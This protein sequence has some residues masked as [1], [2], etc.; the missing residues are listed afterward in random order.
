M[1]PRRLDQAHRVLDRHQAGHVR[2]GDP[3]PEALL[4]SDDE[5]EQGQGVDREVVAETRGER[6]LVGRHLE[7]LG[8]Q[9]G[10]ARVDLVEPPR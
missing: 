1:R 4:D 3:H 8:E 9:L 7:D 10:D 2:V 6:H 5:L